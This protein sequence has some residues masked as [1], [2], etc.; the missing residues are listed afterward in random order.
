LWPLPTWFSLQRRIL[1]Q[2]E[3]LHRFAADSGGKFVLIKSRADL[4]QFL[5]A[6][7]ENK[8]MV[9]GFLGIEGA[10]AIE[11]DL[12]DFD[13]LYDAGV[14]MVAFTHFFDTALAGSAHGMKK[15]G[16]TEQ[17][18]KFLEK[19]MRRNVVIDVAHVSEAAIVD[20]LKI[21]KKPVLVSHTG[22]RGTCDN[23]RNISDN[24]VKKISE[25]GGVIGVGFFKLAVC[26]ARVEHI[27]KAMAYIKQLVGIEHV[28]LGSDYDGLVAVPVTAEQLDQ[29]TAALLA[30]THRT[31]FSRQD[32]AKIMGLNAI[33]VLKQNL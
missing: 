22:V 3:K 29:I 23:Q 4:D 1:Y 20:I 21:V 17:G 12:N 5:L 27:V 14:R 30:H 24:L 25:N 33:R 18:K 13:R 32:I 2:T 16:L 26:G 19:L 15:G 31:S 11:E 28:A 6:R 10:M 9:A 7:A 8:N